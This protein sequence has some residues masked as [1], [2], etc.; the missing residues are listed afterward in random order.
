MARRF[1]SLLLLFS[2]SFIVGAR[3]LEAAAVI[4]SIYGTILQILISAQI[5]QK[6]KK[7]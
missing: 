4:V 5:G 2:L 7:F 3:L 1:L 6:C